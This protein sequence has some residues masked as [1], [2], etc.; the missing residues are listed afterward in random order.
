M[1]ANTGDK[2]TRVYGNFRGVDFRGEE[3]NISRSPDSLNVWRDYKSTDSIKTRPAFKDIFENN[4]TSNKVVHGIYFFKGTMLAHVGSSI[5]K[6]EGTTSTDL[7]YTVANAP[8]T[9]FVYGD[10][11]YFIDGTNYR[12]YDGNKLTPVQGYI[13]TVSIGGKAVAADSFEL[14]GGTTH[15]DVN[16]LANNRIYTYSGNKED[17]KTVFTFPETTGD[18]YKRIRVWV[19]ELV[20][21]TNG[22]KDKY[23]WVE[24]V[25]EH[26]SSS[27]DFLADNKSVEFETPMKAPMRPLTEGQDNVK[28]QVP[29]NITYT[30]KD[31]NDVNVANKILRCTTA[32]VFDNRVFFSGNKDFPNTIFHS[33]LD[34]PTYFSDLDYYDEGKNNASVRGMVAG[35]NAL[36]VFREPTDT[37]DSVFY[38]VPTI[39][40]EY[41][42]VYPS[43]HSSVSLG[44]VGRAINFNDDIVFY[45]DRGLE[46]ISGDITSEQVAM[47][48]SSTVDS[49]LISESDYKDMVLE[50][51]EGYLL[52]F[53]GNKVYVADSR[54]MYTNVNH[55]EYE[56]FYWDLGELFYVDEK[57]T[58]AKVYNGELYIGT[59]K[60]RIYQATKE[61]IASYYNYSYWITPKDKFNAPNKLKTTNK[62]GCVV[63]AKGDVTVFVSIDGGV[64][65]EIGSFENIT[66]YFAC[67]IKR[68]KFKEI[69]LM[70]QSNSSFSLDTATLECF[71]GGYIKR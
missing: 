63:E 70:F 68:K 12:V 42:K 19:Y 15:E 65:E 60:G 40:S 67:R 9:A 26:K 32:Q 16:L 38:H 52:T 18:N 47:H 59:N 49:K 24:K 37:Q 10:K 31:G 36:W 20:K 55:I 21:G 71:I 43:S 27:F 13:P 46:G 25:S 35:N 58:S 57:V 39:D 45:S 53:I 54:A 33:S 14:S 28:I 44:C 50:E 56:H 23:D 41:G 22:E 64:F 5:Y 69:Q 61:H 2:I 6:I 66:D 62:R 4:N 34:D 51:W 3:I 8:S 11:L 17:E 29:Y 30:D 48:R 7:G 1:S